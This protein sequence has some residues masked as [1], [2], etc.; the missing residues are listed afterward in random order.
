MG[1]EVVPD[2]LALVTDL[3][4]TK[5]ADDDIE[6]LAEPA[7]LARWFAARGLLDEGEAVTQAEL[8]RTIELREALRSYVRDHHGSGVAPR[9][10]RT[11]NANAEMLP[12]RLTFGEDGAVSFVPA[13]SGVDA[14]LAE[15]LAGIPIALSTGSWNRL[16]VCADDA[17]Q[18]A[19]YDGSKNRSKRW[20][21]MRSCG[22]KNKTRA[23]RER[24]KTD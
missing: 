11:I 6:E 24:K 2:E 19:F 12:Y 22:N 7:D 20:C 4:N 1:A 16:K 10:L 9:A 8:E 21:S 17:C 14:A 23:Y 18:W 3:L 15:V 13:A 5:E